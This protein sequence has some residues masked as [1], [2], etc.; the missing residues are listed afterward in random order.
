MGNVQAVPAQHRRWVHLLSVYRTAASV[1]LGSI[2]VP[3]PA[4]GSAGVRA[5]CSDLWDGGGV[6]HPLRL[7]RISPRSAHSGRLGHNYG[8][9]GP[10]PEEARSKILPL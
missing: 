8:H 3:V 5:G 10:W 6:A 9:K 7:E 2:G 4:G 1:S